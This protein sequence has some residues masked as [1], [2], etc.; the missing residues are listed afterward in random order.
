MKT[1]SEA[2]MRISIAG[3]L[4]FLATL[5]ATELLLY[6]FWL[7]GNPEPTYQL[8]T[9]IVSGCV[10]LFLGGWITTRVMESEEVWFSAINGLLVGGASSYFLIGFQPL[11]IILVALSFIFS[12][13]G[14]YFAI[15]RKMNKET[16]EV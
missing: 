15:Q 11:L 7:A 1:R 3:F 10:G 2:I 8:V 14:G 16:Q 9:G 12:G 6:L 13:L 5:S 4:S